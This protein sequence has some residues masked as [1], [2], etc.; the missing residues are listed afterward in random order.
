MENDSSNKS[1]ND[2]F[3]QQQSQK[4]LTNAI[5]CGLWNATK[6]APRGLS[7]EI[8]SLINIFLD[9]RLHLIFTNFQPYIAS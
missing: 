9:C 6:S 1:L 2:L 4:S 5:I 7:T 3:K 8:F